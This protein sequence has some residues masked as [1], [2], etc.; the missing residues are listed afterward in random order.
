MRILGFGLCHQLSERSFAAGGV[1]LPVCARDTGIYIGFV[2]CVAV[3]Q[4]LGRG[5][6]SEPPGWTVSAIAAAFLALMVIDGVT[7]YAGIRATTNDI[8]LLTGLTAGFAIALFATPIVNGQLWREPSGE[9]VL[10]PGR[11]LAMWLAALPATFVVVRWLL[12][13]L[14][15]LYPVAVALSILATFWWVNLAIV[16]LV[17]RFER[18]SDRLFGVWPAHLFALA[19]SVVEI[20]AGAVFRA[21]AEA[22]AR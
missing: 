21:F 11:E 7:S 12:P 3:L 10:S 13:L 9:R 4:A 5:R 1:Q 6:R 22:L 19:L 15:A 18:K 8:R 20:G 17:P 16:C 14:G 2:T